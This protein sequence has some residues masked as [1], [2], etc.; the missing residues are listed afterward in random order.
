MKE[1]N[2]L[3]ERAK[4]NCKMTSH[5]F[6]ASFLLCLAISKFRTSSGWTYNKRGSLDTDKDIK[7]G[8]DTG[9]VVIP[10][11]IVPGGNTWCGKAAKAAKEDCNLMEEKKRVYLA[12]LIANCHL[13]SLNRPIVKWDPKHALK[14]A[15]TDDV[16]LVVM[17]SGQLESLCQKFGITWSYALAK[18][19]GERFK[20][21]RA[22]LKRI[23]EAS[24]EFSKSGAETADAVKGVEGIDERMQEVQRQ[25]N[26]QTKS[27]ESLS[28]SILKDMETVRSAGAQASET[29]RATEA[30]IREIGTT[31][32]DSLKEFPAVNDALARSSNQFER[33]MKEHR[34]MPPVQI[35]QHESPATA[36]S[37]M[38]IAFVV[39]LG[40]L[41]TDRASRVLGIAL[42]IA[43]LK[44]LIA[45][46]SGSNAD[47]WGWA[48]MLNPATYVWFMSHQVLGIIPY[49]SLF[50]VATLAILWET[51]PSV[52]RNTFL[53]DRTIL[54][55]AR[56]ES[57]DLIAS[58]MVAT[59]T[60]RKLENDVHETKKRERK[61]QTENDAHAANISTKDDIIK[62]LE[63]QVRKSRNLR[64]DAANAISS[65]QEQTRQANEYIDRQKGL[66]K[67]L[68]S[69][70]D[71]SRS[72]VDE[73]KETIKQLEN[74]VDVGRSVIA[75]KNTDINDL[76]SR[77]LSLQAR[78][79]SGARKLTE[80]IENR[81]RLANMLESRLQQ[82]DEMDTTKEVLNKEHHDL[83]SSMENE[84]E[85]LSSQ[86]EEQDKL[87]EK[88]RG[89]NDKLKR[90][91][92]DTA[93]QVGRLVERESKATLELF[94]L[95]RKLAR[96][97]NPKPK[98]VRS[99]SFRRSSSVV[100]KTGTSSVDV[101]GP[102][103]DDYGGVRVKDDDDSGSDDVAE[104]EEEVAESAPA[105][106]TRSARKAPAGK[107]STSAPSSK[108]EET[109]LRSSGILNLF[110]DDPV[111]AEQ[112][113]P[114]QKSQPAR[115]EAS[116]AHGSKT[117]LSRN[118]SKRKH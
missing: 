23:Q 58:Q 118:S 43:V 54:A 32:S 100:Q 15:A 7:N 70:V 77:Y 65:I 63:E 13:E 76:Q 27:M 11:G 36:N 24:A 41:F 95:K 85:S 6:I 9:T 71:V 92:A 14:Y 86:I 55:K 93:A 84:I 56:L 18:E 37:V 60:I 74:E 12:T 78:E 62:D 81:Q 26:D 99:K 22:D 28:K 101:S 19:Q 75:E 1:T 67:Q 87:I 109:I 73:Q 97:A 113:A 40:F 34:E 29:Q 79:H 44:Y 10:D 8:G 38:L 98:P 110:S 4:H 106:N 61:V 16:Y 83:I 103:D 17:V 102:V 35:Q 96:E 5:R 25:V 80:S 117:R 111:V 90:K 50:L 108:G 94:N 45:P 47:M 91:A 33:M 112:Q 88:H 52:V 39:C 51:A 46:A 31:L 82:A 59:E 104:I 64:R 116:T 68:E 107:A 3:S 21:I 42:G 105:R 89:D 53:G 114:P 72:T 20:D 115:L 69:D 30:A 2:L 57:A 66:I 49:Q 48:D